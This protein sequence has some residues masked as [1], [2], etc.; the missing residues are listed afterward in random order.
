MNTEDFKFL[1]CNQAAIEIYQLPSREEVLGKTPVDVS[2][3]YQ[4]DGILS[5][6]KAEYYC[7]MALE[8]GNIIFNWRH[9][10]PNGQLWDAE[11][12]LRSF[13][14]NKKQYLQFSIIDITEQKKAEEALR[15]SEYLART[16]IEN[17]SVGI[18]VRSANGQLLFYN[19]AW[20]DM[21]EISEERLQKDLLPREKLALNE[22]DEYLS[23]HQ[24]NVLKVYQKGGHYFI[25]ELLTT[26]RFSQSGKQRHISQHFSGILNEQG[27]VEKVVI[28][29]TDV[30]EVKQAE[31][32]K[33]KLKNQLYHAQKM[34]SVGRLAGGVAHDFNNMLGVI[35][36]YTD[37]AVAAVKEDSPLKS[38][39]SEISKAAARSANLTRQLLAFARKQTVRP[40]I[41]DLNES[42]KQLR[43]MLGRLIGED[44]T[45]LFLPFDKPV[46]IEMDP[47]QLDQ[48]LA[49]LCVNAR[50][51]ISDNGKISI[52][53]QCVKITEDYCHQHIT[54]ISGEYALIKVQ[55]NGSGMDQQTQENAFEPFYT[56]KEAGKGTGLGLATVYGIVRQNKGF[57]ELE[58]ELGKGTCFKVYL[59]V[60]EPLNNIINEAQL[61]SLKSEDQTS[62]KNKE[63]IL[64]VE[65]EKSLL[66]MTKE[67]LEMSGYQV[68]ATDSPEEALMLANQYK[69]SIQ[70][71]LTDVI[72]PK[73]NGKELSDEI[74]AINPAIK[75]V[76][77]SGYTAN[78]IEHHGVLEQGV[79]FLQK[80][81][82]FDSLND[83]IRKALDFDE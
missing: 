4:Y 34:E 42:V 57:I 47:S 78:V 64:L 65:D 82:S 62:D 60:F 17:T 49:N 19:Q 23:D 11:V 18:S 71:L 5:S 68:F 41:M 2:S 40:V 9:Q 61:E 79:H 1:D 24:K 52:E 59:P 38:Y 69:H 80:P 81:F 28:I 76:F 32:E 29:S 14:I 12:H 63:V 10:R 83:I 51:A 58:S 25:P 70:L 13:F 36:G 6:I 73:I 48:I 74:M 31:E 7:K 27:T 56:T 53:T 75:R 54:A 50:D 44:I 8:K 43:K 77:M 66:L 26:G 30:T 67:M 15:Q 3:E 16:V 37:L 33:E 21:W 20:R 45:L 46:F 22:R 35:I 39:L 72:M 55:D